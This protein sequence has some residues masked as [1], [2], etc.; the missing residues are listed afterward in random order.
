MLSKAFDS[1]NKVRVG[2]RSNHFGKADK[3]KEEYTMNRHVS[4]DREPQCIETWDFSDVEFRLVEKE[5]LPVDD[6]RVAVD[7]FRKYMLLRRIYRSQVLPMPSKLVDEVW[8]QFILFTKDYHN[9]CN[10]VFG[11]YIHHQPTTA[12]RQPSRKSIQQF[13]RSYRAQFGEPPSIWD[14]EENALTT[15][16]YSE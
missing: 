9:F 7:E 13:Y 10:Y 6:V 8:H 15:D 1:R 5:G 12:S 4:I 14:S 16:C 3:Y 11:E 2:L